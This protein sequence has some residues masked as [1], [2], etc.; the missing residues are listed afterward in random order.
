[1]PLPM[2]AGFFRGY[3]AAD[4]Y[5]TDFRAAGA[6]IPS[7]FT[8]TRAT[9]AWD[10]SLTSYASGVPVINSTRGLYVNNAETNLFLNSTSPVTRTISSL[11]A[12][13][14]VCWITGS[15]SVA[16]SGGATGTATAASP[17]SFTLASAANTTF[18]VSGTV[19]FVSVSLGTF[20]RLPIVTSG[21]SV[22][23][24][25]DSCSAT[26][27][28]ITAGT[29]AVWFRTAKGLGTAAQ[30]LWTIDDG[31]TSNSWRMQRSSVGSVQLV[32]MSGGTAATIGAGTAADST[33]VCAVA[34]FAAGDTVIRSSLGFSG[35]G[36]P[37]LPATA[38]TTERLGN[39]SSGL[40]HESN[41]YRIAR[42]STRLADPYLDAL[43]ATFR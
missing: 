5:D 30:V 7:G 18:T 20:P 42:W 19:T 17:F 41:I 12:G 22:V 4:V 1:M 29:V 26:R 9:T 13:T 31:T 6:A 38:P 40:R 23:R 32:R 25:A 39:T 15:G 43:T 10:E 35:T 14:Y 3:P 37:A 2:P 16:V 28:A 33:D 34:A 36:S 21:S 27:S 8:F 11:A 24:N